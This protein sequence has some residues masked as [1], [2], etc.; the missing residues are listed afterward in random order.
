[1]SN[2]HNKD[3]NEVLREQGADLTNGL[4]QAE[5]L[6]RQE[7][8]G[9]NKFK[10]E[11]KESLF[12]QIT[13]HL[14]DLAIIILLIAAAL[15]FAMDIAAATG[16]REPTALPLVKGF[17]I[18]GIVILNTALAVIQERGA[19]KALEALAKL[20]SPSCFVIRDGVKQEISTTEVVRGDIIVLKSGDLVPADARIV[21]C[22]S[23]AVDE[24]S[25]TG[26]SEPSKKKSEVIEN[27]NIP[28]GD[29]KNLVFSGCLVAKGHAKAVVVDTGM[30]TEMGK[31]ASFLH[32]TKKHMTPLQ[33]RIQR[34]SRVICAIA[35]VSALILLTVS[36]IQTSQLPP[37]ERDYWNLAF[38]V[39]TLAVAAVPEAMM[40]IVTL[41][42]THGVQKMVKKNVIIRKLPAVETLGS[43]SVICSDK[44]GTL[45][46]N[47]MSI[48]RLWRYGQQP[49][50][51]TEMASDDDF[52]FL[53]KL[54]LVS[55]VSLEK[56]KDGVESIIG[57]PT[58]SA[59]M[60]LAQAK[61]IVKTELEAAYP[62][63]GEIPFSSSRKMMT[64]VVKMPSGKFL[65][66]TKGAFDRL[67]FGNKKDYNYMHELS[68][69]HDAFAEDALRL[70][71]LAHKEVD[72][73]PPREEWEEKLEAGLTFDGFVGII[74]PPRP[75]AAV[76]IAQAKK[77]G[78]RTIMITGD[79]AAT[80]TAIAR[81]L[82][83]IVG[84]EGVITGMELE[85]L[86]EDELFNSVHHYSVYARVS[87]EDKI[88]IVQAWQKHGQVVAMTGDGV[89]DAPA[90]KGADI[91]VAMGITGTEVSKSAAD[92]TLTDDNFKS[93]VSG[94]VEGRNVFANIRKLVYF[95]IVCNFAEIV[96][97]LFGVV[98]G[99]GLP[100]TPLM[101]LIINVLADGV[102]GLALAKEEADPRIMDRKPFSRNES[103]FAGGLLQGIIRQTLITSFIALV[104]FYIGQNVLAPYQSAPYRL[105][106][107]QTM[108]F[109][110]LGWASIIHIFTARSRRSAFAISPFKNKGMTFSALGMFI[111]LAVMVLIPQFDRVI[112]ATE[113]SV[114]LP[115]QGWLIALG[116]CFMP[117]I[118]AEY[119]KFWDNYKL[120]SAKE[121]QVTHDSM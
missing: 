44:T 110:A 38:I 54:L 47:R 57:D 53:K 31:I 30:D 40:V 70:I 17:V 105:A 86:T 77:A 1:L 14:K 49:I 34:L 20:N 94:V 62:R 83:I 66:L 43:T 81:E 100:L 104:A 51:E 29:R 48:T 101:L 56:D 113:V 15:A 37:A 2:W 39:V 32:T 60:R 12:V 106:L 5:V 25:L 92:I 121:A 8:F 26:E 4:T 79:H 9:L 75:E 6:E 119:G 64:T 78:I 116:L 61:D 27:E 42:L 109:L 69:V 65:V 102:P 76:A 28:L 50:K 108:T 95:L 23:F 90:L 89:N 58:E 16:L 87:P 59:I 55:N 107:G 82:G 3:K 118:V 80:A 52:W 21:E 74:D 46:Q 7:K 19:Q 68:E 85:K 120:K 45:T 88:R 63:V 36:L 73:L 41:T 13:R 10:E 84:K 72:T 115:W 97:M 18:L 117:I 35:V 111:A 33:M 103:F 22:E 67:P 11:K 114:T 112:F 98:S 96:I 93:I 24:A 91:G 99:W 71:A